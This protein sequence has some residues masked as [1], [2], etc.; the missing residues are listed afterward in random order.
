MTRKRTALAALVSLVLTA[1]IV[2][3]DASTAGA[4]DGD[5][6]NRITGTWTA[7]INLPAPA[8]PLRSLQTFSEG[9]GFVEMSN[10][11]QASR[12]AQYGSWERISGR[13]YAATGL[14]FRYN[15]AGAHVATMKI[16]RTIRL[17][18]DGQTMAWAARVTVTDPA[19]NVQQTFPVTSSAE[20][21]QVDRIADQP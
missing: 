17:S 12:T 9:G 3:G 21:L 4:D 2:F 7:T 20:R 18:K 13:L 1:S 11:P 19:G 15:P 14:V 8:A 10:E 5:S 16:D 6:G